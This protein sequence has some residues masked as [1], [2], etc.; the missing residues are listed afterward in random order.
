MSLVPLLV[1]RALL[2][3][4]RDLLSNLV[5]AA[6]LAIALELAAERWVDPD[7]PRLVAVG[8]VA[9]LLAAGRFL[10][11]SWRLWAGRRWRRAAVD[12]GAAGG[13]ARGAGEG[14]TPAD[15]GTGRNTSG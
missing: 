10:R 5:A 6:V 14:R 12:G 8:L 4:L 7:L 13:F 1:L 15:A 3:P 11:A 9:A 2:A